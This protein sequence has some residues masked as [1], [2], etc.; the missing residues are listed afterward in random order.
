MEDNIPAVKKK[1]WFEELLEVQNQISFEKNSKYKGTKIKV[2]VEGI[3]PK[4]QKLL[5]GRTENNTVVLF[6]GEK[7]LI[8]SIIDV[9][10]VET[11]SFYIRGNVSK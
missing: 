9:K 11:K 8:G 3:S 5:Q 7:H 2:L 4:N 1:K 10:I 6:K